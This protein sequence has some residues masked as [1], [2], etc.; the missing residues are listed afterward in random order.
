V[1]SSRPDFGG[2]E[3]EPV[4]EAEDRVHCTRFVEGKS[5]E[6]A[7]EGVGKCNDVHTSHMS[8]H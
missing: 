4:E 1:G 2:S 7:L 3:Q 8:E 5:A 6:R